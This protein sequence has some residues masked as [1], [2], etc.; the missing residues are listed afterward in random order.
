MKKKILFVMPNLAGGGAEKVLVNILNNID[1]QNFDI[2]LFLFQKYGIYIKQVNK[3]VKLKYIT[4][5]FHTN[6]VNT[7][8]C[9]LLKY[10]PKVIYK[11][12]IKETYDVEI[13]FMEGGSTNIIANSTNK[14][15]KKIAWI[16]ADLHKFHWTENLYR[17]NEECKCYEKFNDLVFVSKDAKDAFNE[18]FKNNKV[19]KHIIFNPIVTDEILKKSEEFRVRY[20]EFTVVSVGRLSLEKGY[21]RLI[22]AHSTLV[23]Q[24]P[25]KLVILGEG[26]ERSNLEKL[27]GKLGVGKS[28]ELKGFMNNPYPYIKEADL[29][30]CSSRSEGY[31]L[32][33]AEALVL[34]KPVIATD[35][36]GPREILQNGEYGFLCDS[37]KEGLEA[38]LRYLFENRHKLDYYK[39][40]SKMAKNNFN[41]KAIINKIEG[42]ISL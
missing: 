19:N 36:T 25:H 13:A 9:K 38:A 16:H 31:P 11:L 20:N 42:L 22:K 28:V 27:I 26:K 41:Y 30:V 8:I 34:G 17:H 3:N 4:E 14:E 18:L 37:S 29:F 12:F 32:V 15:S 7:I 23:K 5:K 21:D 24:Y 10:A 40:K 35:V 1:Y 2:T 6:F 39:E 33:V